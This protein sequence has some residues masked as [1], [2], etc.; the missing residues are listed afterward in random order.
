MWHGDEHDNAASRGNGGEE[1]D[2]PA[3]TNR[4][5]QRETDTDTDNN[6]HRAIS[7]VSQQLQAGHA[8]RD[9]RELQQQQQ[10]QPQRYSSRIHMFTRMEDTILPEEM[11]Y[12]PCTHR[13]VSVTSGDLHDSHSSLDSFHLDGFH[14]DA[15]GGDDI[16]LDLSMIQDLHDDGEEPNR[17]ET[18]ASQAMAPST[19]TTAGVPTDTA[20][21][22]AAAQQSSSRNIQHQ[23]ERS[24]DVL[25]LFNASEMNYLANMCLSDAEGR[26]C[27]D[28][29][30]AF[31]AGQ[32][33]PAPNDGQISG[34]V[35]TQ[36]NASTCIPDETLDQ[37]RQTLPRPFQ[38]TKQA[39]V[40]NQEHLPSNSWNLFEPLQ[41]TH[42]SRESNNLSP[43][44]SDAA[45]AEAFFASIESSVAEIEQPPALQL[46]QDTAMTGLNINLRRQELRL[47]R[48]METSRG[49]ENLIR[50]FD[51]AQG[52]R[53]CHSKTTLATS[54]SR[55]KLIKAMFGD[56]RKNKGMKRTKAH[57][58]RP[59]KNNKMLPPL[60][61]E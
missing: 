61:F 10:H 19:R 33:V 20:S 2:G 28:A 32:K 24:L 7:H 41:Y 31:A 56:K 17:E 13:R 43:T 48:S 12:E 59:K 27:N 30:V 11:M 9:T 25:S 36:I 1:K 21:I 57:K 53:F 45:A 42:P 49:S 23:R 44:D 4:S 34:D 6:E 22:I 5:M 39:F 47:R 58:G 35:A 16:D 46:Q 40:A 50:S 15:E 52:L 14:L 60:G 26:D 8:E 55:V 3:P 29:M 18:D 38:I 51:R 37:L 54:R